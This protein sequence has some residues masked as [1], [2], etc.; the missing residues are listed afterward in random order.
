MI[1]EIEFSPRTPTPE[2]KSRINLDLSI[3]TRYGI[4]LK[5]PLLTT[6]VIKFKSTIELLT[7]DVQFNLIETIL[8]G[9]RMDFKRAIEWLTSPGISDGY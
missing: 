5:T 1:R 2:S 7:I 6:V 4:H 3:I 8:A 9:V